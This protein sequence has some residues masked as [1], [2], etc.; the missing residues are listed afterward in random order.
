MD[1]ELWE[2]LEECDSEDEVAAIIR[3]GQPGVVPPGVRV[4]AQ[5]GE[6]VTVRMKC[7]SILDIREAAEV[8]SV[9]AEGPPMAPDVELDDAEP[10][11]GLT[12]ATQPSDE[13]WP[14]SLDATGYGVVI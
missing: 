11:E 4:I 10:L 9:K 14:P 3:L 13:R 7:G 12:E 8:V 1:P 6:I 2:M 5:F